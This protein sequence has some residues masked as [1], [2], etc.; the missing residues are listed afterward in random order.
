MSSAGLALRFDSLFGRWPELKAI[1]D[2]ACETWDRQIRP[3]IKKD[4]PEAKCGRIIP[5]LCN[6]EDQTIKFWHFF[7]NT[8]KE[9]PQRP[10]F[11][12]IHGNS[13]EGHESFIERMTEEHIKKYAEDKWQ[14]IL[15][16]NF[17]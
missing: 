5:K 15:P 4:Q 1:N 13:G 12:F 9:C 14:N 3:F 7:T 11:Y 6:R 8:A 16:D 2:N 17:L 10:H